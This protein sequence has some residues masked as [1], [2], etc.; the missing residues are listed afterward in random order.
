MPS[1]LNYCLSAL[2]VG[3]AFKSVYSKPLLHHI[4]FQNCYTLMEKGLV[5]SASGM[6]TLRI[7]IVEE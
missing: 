3:V 2:H 1:V 4:D 5:N 7:A 6:V